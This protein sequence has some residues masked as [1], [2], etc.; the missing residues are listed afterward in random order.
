M[1]GYR[2]LKASDRSVAPD[3]HRAGV[4]R[5]N[6]IQMAITTPP[7]QAAAEV[8]QQGTNALRHIRTAISLWNRFGKSE[9]KVPDIHGR[10]PD[11]CPNE[12]LRTQ[13]ESTLANTSPA[14]RKH[15]QDGR[16]K[17]FVL[18]WKLGESIQ[19]DDDITVRAIEVRGNRL[20]LGIEAFDNMTIRRER[21]TGHSCPGNR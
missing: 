1:T 5:S 15:F 14:N 11:L 10:E 16:M 21:S 4:P 9:M 17:M 20:R 18:N 7:V 6:S 13:T 8:P 19:I 3:H 12:S 2:A